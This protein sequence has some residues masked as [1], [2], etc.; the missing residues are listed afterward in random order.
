MGSTDDVEAVV[1]PLGPSLA[2]GT[3]VWWK[4]GIRSF[5]RPAAEIALMPKDVVDDR[6]WLSEAQCRKALRFL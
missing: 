2:D 4:I 5:D 1:A 6:K 3:P